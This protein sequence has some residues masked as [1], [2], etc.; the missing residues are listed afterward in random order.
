MEKH[1]VYVSTSTL[2][3]LSFREAIQTLLENNIR[4]IELGWVKQFDPGYLHDLKILHRD[5]NL[6]LLIHNYFPPVDPPFV[7]NL[8]SSNAEILARSLA[9]CREAIRLS[10]VFSS[11]FYSVH[12]GFC[13][14]AKPN[15][16]DHNLTFLPRFPMEEGEKRFVEFIQFL[17]DYAKPYVIDIL[18]ENHVLTSWN[19]IDGE[20]K[21]LLGI[22]AEDMIRLLTK[23]NRENI[24][25]L[26]D[27][28]HL[29]VSAHTLG[30]S[31]A[32]FIQQVSSRIKA[33]HLHDNDGIQDVHAPNDGYVNS[34]RRIQ[35]AR[36]SIGK[37]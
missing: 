28:G 12:A 29:R 23:I 7:L 19:V 35:G 8:A 6:Q 16:L 20:N 31:A 14:D 26:L 4:H 10:H 11:P 32:D 13:V 21:I 15:D 30:F 22:T 36:E 17:C 2:S 25:I 24:G 33:V 18:I 27:V 9:L 34:S 5:C 3:S 1:P 37:Y